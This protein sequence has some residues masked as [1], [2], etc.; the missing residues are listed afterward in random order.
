M[1][2]ASL[3]IG[4]VVEDPNWIELE[5]GD[6]TY[7][8][9][10]QLK[11]LIDQKMKPTIAVVMLGNERFYK[12]FKHVCYGNNIISQCIQYKN[13]GKGLNLSVASNI[14]RQINSKLGG[15]LF[16]LKFAK[17][18][19]PLTM[20]IGID[21][22]HSGPSSIV[23]FCAS[24]NKARSQYYSERIVQKKGQ[25]IVNKQLKDAIKRALGCF[26]EKHGDFPQHFIIYRDGVGDGM[27]KQVLQEEVTQ[28]RQAIIETYNTAKKKPV[29][30]VIIVNKRIT[31]RFFIEDGR[32]QLIN[33]PSGAL[34]DS[35]IVENQ[36]SQSEYDF[37]L[38]PQFTTQG[39]VLPTH[40]YVAFN[41]SMVE[42]AT[43][44]KL[45]YDLCHYYF[46][47]AGAIKVP[48]PCMY[49]HKIAELFM[50][51]GKEAKQIEFSERISQS[52]HFL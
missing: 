19:S 47:W 34:I 9:E 44:E 3:K 7:G 46:N 50:N 20:L 11:A 4:I 5:R 31:Q 8:C 27:R 29:I 26:Q 24:I 36:D 33:P 18:L 15:D 25:E 22:C 40:F 49:A 23:G 13:F 45:T 2:Q 6:D 17:E 10:K 48:A 30:T 1:Q 39:C 38:I 35:K 41:D 21:V 42:K 12:G 37:Y 28:F 52:L 16:A 32:G 43:I 51:L 14:L